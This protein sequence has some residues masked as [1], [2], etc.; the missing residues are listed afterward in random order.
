MSADAHTLQCIHHHLLSLVPTTYCRATCLF[1]HFGH[2]CSRHFAS[3]PAK[4][5][6]CS[7]E[8]DPIYPSSIRHASPSFIII[9]H[10]STIHQSST[11]TIKFTLHLV[12]SIL[13]MLLHGIAALRRLSPHQCPC[14]RRHSDC[15]TDIAGSIGRSVHGATS[16]TMPISSIDATI[17]SDVEV[18]SA[19]RN[20]GR[21]R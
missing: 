12:V 18:E 21:E 20:T 19:V 7:I 9:L 1:R 11:A 2:F 8:S 14:R 5:T 10:P 13:L 16:K 15:V 6:A 17:W 3:L 4:S